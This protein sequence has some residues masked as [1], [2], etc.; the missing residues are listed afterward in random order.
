MKDILELILI[1][2]LI[3]NRV[4][5]NMLLGHYQIKVLTDLSTKPLIIIFSIQNPGTV[6]NIDQEDRGK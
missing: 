3:V 1:Q 4:P 6:L 5:H 2:Q